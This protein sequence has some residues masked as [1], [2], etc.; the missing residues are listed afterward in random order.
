[1]KSDDNGT[2]SISN[3]SE[4]HF[5]D[6]LTGSSLAINYPVFLVLLFIYISIISFAVLG[7]V[8]VILAF[9]RSLTSKNS[10]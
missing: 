7:S 10:E 9:A 3:T 4:S 1:M 6:T 5:L 8:L 2:I